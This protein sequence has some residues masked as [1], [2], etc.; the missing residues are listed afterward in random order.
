MI[1]SFVVS[2]SFAFLD[3]YV[4]ISI[5]SLAQENVG[6][7]IIKGHGFQG[8]GTIFGP[9]FLGLFGEVS[10]KFYGILSLL[11]GIPLLL[12]NSPNHGTQNNEKDE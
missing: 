10:L 7:Y 3:I 9:F 1:I 2:L 11:C 5:V 8:M 6:N 12:I 4:N